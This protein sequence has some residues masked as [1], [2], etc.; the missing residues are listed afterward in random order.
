MPWF[1]RV[2][3]AEPA[4]L[5]VPDPGSRRDPVGLGHQLAAAS[6]TAIAASAEPRS[7]L[8][9]GADLRDGVIE[10]VLEGG[11]HDVGGRQPWAR[12]RRSERG[13]VGRPASAGAALPAGTHAATAP[14]ALRS[15]NQVVA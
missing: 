2:L 12:A 13:R 14:R 5:D 3:A 9:A 7:A 4:A 6:L 8:E 15:T 11:L 10:V 1:L